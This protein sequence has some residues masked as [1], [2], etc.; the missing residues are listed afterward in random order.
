MKVIE[1]SNNGSKFT[2]Y[3]KSIVNKRNSYYGP[4]IKK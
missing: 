4:E 1:K 2:G 3:L